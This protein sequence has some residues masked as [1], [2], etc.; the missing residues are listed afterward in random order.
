MATER[1][2][3]IQADVS[4]SA[5]PLWERWAVDEVNEDVARVLIS[6]ALLHALIRG[7]SAELVAAQSPPMS[8][9]TPT[10]SVLRRRAM[11]IDS[12]P[13]S[14]TWG[15][16]RAVSFPR[17][18]LDS[19]LR[20]RAG[21]PGLPEPRPVREGDAFW[22]VIAAGRPDGVHLAD[23]DLDLEAMAAGT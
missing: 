18:R 9:L 15:D 20:G 13:A 22:V 16:E 3:S 8:V 4:E 21:K 6:R 14:E 2:F 11:E 1:C 23:A 12:A 19:F 5:V 10:R 7:I 17:A